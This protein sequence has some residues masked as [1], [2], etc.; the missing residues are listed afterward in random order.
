MLHEQILS[1]DNTYSIHLIKPPKTTDTYKD[2]YNLC[3]EYLT[4]IKNI[5]TVSLEAFDKLK[6]VLFGISDVILRFIN[7]VKVSVF[8][9][10]K[11]LKRSEL[12]AYHNNHVLKA[13]RALN[14]NYEDVCDLIVPI[15]S[16]MV[17]TYLET[18]N[19]LMELL[20]LLDIKNNLP[21][22]I[23]IIKNL[24]NEVLSESINVS[25]LQKER[26]N[27][28]QEGNAVA[29]I[30]KNFNTCFTTKPQLVKAN[31]PFHECFT[32]MDD[33]KTVDKLLLDCEKQLMFVSKA[34]SQIE[35]IETHS[36]NMV[37]YIL[38]KK[39]IEKSC[40]ENIICVIKNLAILFETYGYGIQF[41]HRLEHN[42]VQVLSE[43]IKKLKY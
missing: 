32:S 13:K 37:D 30:K 10:F 11:T 3:D 25:L 41:I 34:S 19:K 5:D 28:E 8:H 27:L 1:L 18:T 38:D 17:T 22:Y 40:L 9:A 21:K 39:T 42:F 33:F 14:S 23:S 2:I 16:G 4:T 43:I 24:S 15:P 35:D 29:Q 20:N 26:S 6:S 12:R 7:V 31:R 36:Q